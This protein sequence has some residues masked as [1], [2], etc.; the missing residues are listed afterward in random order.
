MTVVG[1]TGDDVELGGLL[2]CPDVDTVLFLGGGELD[3][4]TWWGIAGDTTELRRLA[5]AAGP[6]ASTTG[7]RR[8]PLR[9][10]LATLEPSVHWG[11]EPC[12]A[13]VSRISSTK[14]CPQCFQEL[15]N[16]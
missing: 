12:R 5:D 2:V 9:C 8:I 4:D 16:L 1:N 6:G 11:V 10:R 3:R 13:R 7:Y 14:L 15:I